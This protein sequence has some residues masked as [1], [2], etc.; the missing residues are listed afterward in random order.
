MTTLVHSPTM[1]METIQREALIVLIKTLNEELPHQ[2]EI[3]APLDQELAELRE[4]DY[5]P[6]TVEPVAPSNFY[7]GHQP[8]LINGPMDKYPNV[9]VMTDRAGE[10]PFESIDQGSSY[11]NRLWV[12]FLVKGVNEE[13]VN[14]RTQRMAD[15]VNICMMSNQTLNGRVAGFDGPPEVILTEVFYRKEKT[16]YGDQIPIQGGRL[17]YVVTKEASLPSGDFFR[18]ASMASSP[19]NLAGMNIDQA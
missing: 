4:I 10:S 9:S 18:P 1:G 5:M 11:R 15:A 6:I 3:W 16:S 12:E 2:D 7:S 17:E 19:S 13:E 8:S 14:A